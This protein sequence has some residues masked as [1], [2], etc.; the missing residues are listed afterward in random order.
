MREM[1]FWQVTCIAYRFFKVLALGLVQAGV[2]IKGGVGDFYLS[3]S[4]LESVL[5]RR[6]LSVC[7]SVHVFLDGFVKIF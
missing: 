7:L 2:R 5:K 3:S 4:S 1:W 6:N